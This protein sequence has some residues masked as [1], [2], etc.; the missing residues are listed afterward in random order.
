MVRDRQKMRTDGQNGRTDD[1]KTISLRLRR[2]IKIWVENSVFAIQYIE[3][4][5][6]KCFPPVTKLILLH[7]VVVL[8]FTHYIKMV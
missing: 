1:A 2:G 5:L 8:H 6:L 3:N 7:T 4:V